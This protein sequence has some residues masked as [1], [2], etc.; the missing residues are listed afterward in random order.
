M[1][2][3]CLL[4]EDEEG[5]NATTISKDKDWIGKWF[6]EIRPWTPDVV[7]NELL[8]YIRCYGVSCHAWSFK[9][10]D[11]ITC[12]PGK[13]VY[14]DKETNKQKNMDVVHILVRTKYSFDLNE[15][16]NVEI[17]NNIFN[18]KL[19]EDMHGRK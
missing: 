1:E 13:L 18:V 3:L 16:F 14:L 15:N 17:N 5:E 9:F 4:E 19:V 6:S 12:S 7:D 11:F 2:N 8:T 10:L